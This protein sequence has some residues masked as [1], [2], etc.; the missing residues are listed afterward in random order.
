MLDK[1]K[2]LKSL[3]I[4]D[5]SNGLHSVYYTAKVCITGLR[6]CVSERWIRPRADKKKKKKNPLL[7][8]NPPYCSRTLAA[9]TL[10]MV[11]EKMGEYIL[12]KTTLAKEQDFL[13]ERHG[14]K[15]PPVLRSLVVSSKV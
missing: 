15:L 9:W 4:L 5:D 10:I 6:F 13:S 14:L 1:D 8:S 3:K 11:F 2:P 12:L 7:I